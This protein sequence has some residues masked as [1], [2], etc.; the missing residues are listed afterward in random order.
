MSPHPSLAPMPT[1]LCH[2]FTD[3]A[4]EMPEGG[5]LASEKIDGWRAPWYRSDFHTRNG[6]TLNGVDHLAPVLRMMEEIAGGPLFFDAEFQ[7][8]GTL[9]ATK[10]YC[11]GGW[12]AGPQGKLYLFDML[13]MDDWR[14]GG[15]DLLLTDRLALLATLY[16]QAR[17]H[18]LSWELEPRI[19]DGVVILPHEQMDC[20]A[21][22]RRLARLVWDNGGEGLVLKSPKSPYVRERTGLWRK[23]KR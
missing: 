6:M 2:L 5:W 18:P 15:G 16:E 20:P 10:A 9:S 8:G 12:K 11:E 22:I 17:V 1:H 13:P 21:A 23:V 4:G 19:W 3:W 14:A 7:V